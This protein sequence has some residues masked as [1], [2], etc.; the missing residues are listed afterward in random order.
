M[1]VLASLVLA[2]GCDHASPSE[3]ALTSK[4]TDS[5][6]IVRPLKKSQTDWEGLFD[7][8]D[9][10][11]RWANSMGMPLISYDANRL[12]PPAFFGDFTAIEFPATTD[13]DVNSIQL[14]E[15][16][17]NPD[18]IDEFDVS[19]FLTSQS[20]KLS[21]RREFKRIIA[22]LIADNKLTGLSV[23]MKAIDFDKT[24]EYAVG[25][26]KLT[27]RQHE[28]SSFPGGEQLTLV[29]HRP[30]AVLSEE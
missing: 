8:P 5:P 15:Y 24:A 13:G 27:V 28:I 20:L 2:G 26:I 1:A 22:R 29:F 16:G 12:P 23:A 3:N 10:M 11:A 17:M 6:P 9:Q 18:T 19:L 14:G 30:G 4:K 7:R 25:N 21:A